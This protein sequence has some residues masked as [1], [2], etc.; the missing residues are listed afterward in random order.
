MNK[1]IEEGLPWL[2]S[3][4]AAVLCFFYY[5][6]WIKVGELIDKFP[7]IGTF[8]FGFLLTLFGLIHQ[9]SSI[10]I[11][12]FKKQRDLYKRFVHLNRNAVYVSLALTL[13]A[14]M[15][16]NIIDLNEGATIINKVFVAIFVGGLVY[17]MITSI[18]FLMVFYKLVEIDT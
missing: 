1:K 12:N 15:V 5:P 18:Y 11:E 16:N 13:Y 9:G 3:L 2:L 4:L 14:Y 7:D 8:T 6:Y 10:V 17:F